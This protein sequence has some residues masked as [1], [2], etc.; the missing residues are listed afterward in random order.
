MA[1]STVAPV[2]PPATSPQGLLKIIS[3]KAS[4]KNASSPI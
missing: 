4:V 2:L 3:I 1:I